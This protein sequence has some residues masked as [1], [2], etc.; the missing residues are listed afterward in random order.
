MRILCLSD[1][2]DSLS[3][4]SGWLPDVE[5]RSVRIVA[6]ANHEG[7]HAE[8]DFLASLTLSEPSGTTHRI[9][10]STVLQLQL[11]VIFNTERF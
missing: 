9:L 3:R 6:P 8:T 5:D 1:V 11:D 2:R 7:A 10:P 4:A